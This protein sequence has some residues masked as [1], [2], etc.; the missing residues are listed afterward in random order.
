MPKL[1]TLN[2][3]VDASINE[4]LNQYI[5]VGVVRDDQ[6]RLLLTFGKQITK[7]LS[8]VHGE[9]LAIKEGVN[10][11]YEKKFND[12]QVESDSLLA[13]QTVTT[14]MVN[15]GYVGLCATETRLRIQQP[16][17]TKVIHV[18]RSVNRVAHCIAHFA[19][20]IPSPFI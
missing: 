13:M 20:F 4:E 15:L 16:K 7:P 5:I 10:L 3:N 9:L 12:V 1:G 19:C 14:K 2:L 8:V 6:S 11:L 18:R 17:I